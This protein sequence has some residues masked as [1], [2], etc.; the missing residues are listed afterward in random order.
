MQQSALPDL[1]RALAQTDR[2]ALRHAGGRRRR[3]QAMRPPE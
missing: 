1:D 3:R 2:D